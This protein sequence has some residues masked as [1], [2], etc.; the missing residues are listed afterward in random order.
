MRRLL[1]ALLLLLPLTVSGQTPCSATTRSRC[2]GTNCS[3]TTPSATTTSGCSIGGAGSASSSLLTGLQDY[4]KMD[5]SSGNAAD[6]TSSARTLTNVNATPF[7]AGKLNNAADLE[8]GSTQNFTRA[9][10]PVHGGAFTW[11]FWLNRES[12]VDTVAFIAKWASF[13]NGVEY[14]VYTT[15]GGNNIQLHIADGAAS[16]TATA[17]AAPGAGTWVHVVAWMDTDK[18]PHI[19]L[20]NGTNNAGSALA[21]TPASSVTTLFIGNGASVVVNAD[22]L[23]DEIGFW[24]RALTSTERTCLDGGGTPPAYPFT[25]VC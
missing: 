11:S 6:S 1:A 25:G 3:A 19:Q 15:G 10:F 8:N 23:M 14:L 9:S 2:A 7:V 22:G 13:P 17:V 4:W 18:V 12:V 21:G 16:S 20:N 5:E 24:N